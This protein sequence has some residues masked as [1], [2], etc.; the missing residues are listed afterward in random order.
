MVKKPISFI[1]R[2]KNKENLNNDTNINII[3]TSNRK[4][5]IS[6]TQKHH[7]FSYKSSNS[8]KKFKYF[9]YISAATYL[10]DKKRRKLNS[11][12]I[13]SSNLLKVRSIDY[14]N[15]F[16]EN[17]DYICWYDL[18]NLSSVIKDYNNNV[19]SLLDK[20]SNNFHLNQSNILNQPKYHNGAL[21][22]NGNQYLSNTITT[23]SIQSNMSIYIVMKQ[24]NNNYDTNEQ[25]ILVGHP[26]N[27]T[28]N[29]NNN[30][31]GFAF[32]GSDNTNKYSFQQNYN[33]NSNILV[34]TTNPTLPIDFGLYEFTFNNGEAKLYF[35]GEL[36]NSSTFSFTDGDSGKFNG[37]GLGARYLNGY[38]P[39]FSG[40]VYE[41]IV[42]NNILNDAD[43]YKLEKYLI[44]KWQTSQISSSVN[45]D[46]Y[47]W[48]D[49]SSANNF[50]L[51]G[52][53]VIRW[54]DKNGK[55]FENLDTNT[56]PIFE[57][58]KI[59]LNNQY[60]TFDGELD[61][62]NSTF[63]IICE[64]T[65]ATDNTGIFSSIP[66][67]GIND[68]Q[69]GL[70]FTN[71]SSTPSFNV[72]GGGTFITDNN[73]VIKQVYEVVYN[74]GDCK[75]Y[76]NG[77][78]VGTANFGSLN[79]INKFLLGARYINGVVDQSFSFIG[80]IYEFI[81]IPRVITG[82]EKNK[83]YNYFSAK[84]SVDCKLT[85]PTENSILWFDSN[86]SNYITVNGNNNITGITDISGNNT[87]TIDNT[88]T[89]P[90]LQPIN[91]LNNVNGMYL[92][93]S[94]IGVTNNVP[95]SDSEI[96]FFVVF[97]AS[98]DMIALKNSE[99][100]GRLIG[101]KYTSQDDDD[102]Y[103]FNINSGP[104]NTE[105]ISYLTAYGTQY[106]SPMRYD[107]KLN[108]YSIR[109][110]G[111]IRKLYI[112]DVYVNEFNF[113]ILFN[114][115][116]MNIGNYQI[117]GSNKWKGYLCEMI[118]YNSK[119]SE[120]EYNRTMNYLARKWGVDIKQK[121]INEY[122]NRRKQ[123]E[124]YYLDLNYAFTTNNNYIT[125]S[126]TNNKSKTLNINIT[127]IVKDKLENEIN[128][129]EKD[130]YY[131]NKIE[132]N[133]TFNI[134]EYEQG[135]F[136]YVPNTLQKGDY[137]GI[138]NINNFSIEVKGPNN[139][140]YVVPANSLRYIWYD[141]WI[142]LTYKPAI[143]VRLNNY[144]ATAN[145]N[146]T[147]YLGGWSNDYSNIKKLFVMNADTN[148]L[149][150]ETSNIYFGETY[151]ADFVMQNATGTV[152]IRISD[153]KDV[154]GVLISAQLDQ[155][156]IYNPLSISL[157]HFFNGSD[158]YT[159]ILTNWTY[160][161]TTLDVWVST[162]S[163]FSNSTYLLTSDTIQ[164]SD[165]NYTATFTNTFL[166]G[167]YY[168]TIKSNDNVI[169]YNLPIPIVITGTLSASINN[170]THTP[171]YEITLDGWSQ[172]YTDNTPNLYLYAYLNS[173]YS[174]EP[175]L[176][177]TFTTATD[178]IYTDA[179][180]ITF[181]D[182]FI[183]NR[184]FY[185]KLHDKTTR[186]GY[187]NEEF[188]KNDPNNFIPVLTINTNIDKNIGF[189]NINNVY[190]ITFSNTENY[191]IGTYTNTWYVLIGS[192][193][194]GYNLTLITDT[195]ITN[196]ELTFSY[197]PTNNNGTY[198][199]YVSN[200]NT[201][202]ILTGSD[203][204]I[205]I[206][207]PITF[208]SI[209]AKI[210]EN[211][212]KGL[213]IPL[214]VTGLQAWYDA[215]D[216]TSVTKNGSS[217]T[218]WLDKSG[219]DNDATVSNP[220]NC[221]EYQNDKIYFN[222]TDQ[223]FNIPNETLP[224]NDTSYTIFIIFDAINQSGGFL[225]GGDWGTQGGVN[226]FRGDGSSGI[227]NYWWYVDTNINTGIIGGQ[228][229]ILMGSY[230]S[231]GERR[232][233]L[234]ISNTVTDTPTTRIQTQ[235]NNYIGKTSGGEYL[236]GNLHEILI[237][238]KVLSSDEKQLI[239]GY[240]CWKWGLV[241]NLSYYHKYKFYEPLTVPVEPKNPK[242][243]NGLFSWYDLSNINN[244]NQT[245]LNVSNVYDM[246]GLYSLDIGTIDKPKYVAGKGLYFDG[247][248]YM[249]N[250]GVSMNLNN[251]TIFV[252]F[253]DDVKVNN[254]G[255]ITF[256]DYNNTN[257]TDSGG[258]S[259][260]ND[261]TNN[262][263]ISNNLINLTANNGQ[264]G[265]YVVKN[266]NN[267][268][269]IR[270]NGSTNTTDTYVGDAGVSTDFIMG[271]RYISNNVDNLFN[272]YIKEVVIYN[273]P[274]SDI[275]I[276]DLEGYLAWKWNLNP[277]L[278]NNHPHK[279][280]PY[281]TTNF[282]LNPSS[283]TG[284]LYTWF[285]GNNINSLTLT[286]DEVNTWKD[287]RLDT[288]MT[289][290]NV[291]ANTT[292]I[293]E[294][295]SIEF[296]GT[297][298]FTKNSDYFYTDIP[299]SI[300]IVFKM[301][302]TCDNDGRLLSLFNTGNNDYDEVNSMGIG[303]D[304]SN[305]NIKIFYNNNSYG[306]TNVDNNFNIIEYIYNS[307]NENLYTYLNGNY[308][309]TENISGLALN[310]N[311]IMIGSNTNN[312]YFKGF[313]NEIIINYN[314]IRNDDRQIM[315]GYLAWKWKINNVL[316]GS[317]PYYTSP[318]IVIRPSYEPNNI[319]NL[320]VW[321]DANYLRYNY[322]NDEGV[323][324]WNNRSNFTSFFGYG[325]N[326]PTFKRWGL[327]GNGILDFNTSQSYTLINDNS[328]QY[329]IDNFTFMSVSRLKG[330]T[331][332][333]IFQGVSNNLLIGYWSGR[334]DVVFT[335]GWIAYNDNL[336]DSNWDIYTYVRK[337]DT[338]GY[339]SNRGTEIPLSALSAQGLRGLRYNG[340]ETSDC[341][342]AE[343]LIY[344]KT[345]PLAYVR[346]LEGYLAWKWGLQY[347][348]PI[349]HPYR[350]I[351]PTKDNNLYIIKLEGWSAS[352]NITT[353]Y[354]FDT[355]TEEYLGETEII[356]G[357]ESIGYYGFFNY[358]FLKSENYI[359]VADNTTIGTSTI[360][361]EIQEPLIIIPPINIV[362]ENNDSNNNWAYYNI[363]KTFNFTI[364][365]YY[366]G[367][368]VD[369][370]DYYQTIKVFVGNNPNFSNLT[371]LENANIVG[372]QLSFNINF[373]YA[374]YNTDTLYFYV[375]Y[376]DTP[377]END[378]FVTNAFVFF[379]K[380]V[381]NFTLDHYNYYNPYY[382]TL[383]FPQKIALK[384][385]Y[386]YYSKD[387][388]TYSDNIYAN[389]TYLT[390]ATVNNYNQAQFNATFPA[391]DTGRYYITIS[392]I[393]DG[394]TR[395][396]N[397]INVN[398]TDF[399]YVNLVNYSI[400]KNYGFF[401]STNEYTITLGTYNNATYPFSTI[402]IFYSN[403]IADGDEDLTE[404]ASS[405]I[406]VVNTNN[407]VKATFNFDNSTLQYSTLYFYATA[408]FNNVPAFDSFTRSDLINCFDKANFNFTLDHYDNSSPNFTVTLTGWSE[409]LYELEPL[410]AYILDNTQTLLDIPPIQLNINN[411]E[412]NFVFD[413]GFLD[414]GNYYLRI[415]ES[416]D[417]ND[418]GSTE[419]DY[420]I[421]TPIVVTL[422]NPH[423][424]ITPEKPYR[425]TYN[426]EYGQKI[427]ITLDTYVDNIYLYY[428]ESEYAYYYLTP[429]NDPITENNNYKVN[430]IDNSVILYIT[431]KIT[432]L[433]L[434]C[435]DQDNLTGNNG[436]SSLIKYVEKDNFNITLD[437]YDNTTDN[438]DITLGG[439]DN[440]LLGENIK[441]LSKDSND[442]YTDMNITLNITELNNEFTSNFTYEFPEFEKTKLTL[443]NE[444]NTNLVNI[445]NPLN[446]TIVC[447]N[448]DSYNLMTSDD[449]LSYNRYKINTYGDIRALGYN[450]NIWLLGTNNGAKIYYSYDGKDFKPSYNG[451][452][453]SDINNFYWNGKLWFALGNTGNILWSVNGTEWNGSSIY[454][455]SS[456]FTS[457]TSNSKIT[458]ATNLGAD[459]LCI[460]VDNL[461]SWY[462]IPLGNYT[463]TGGANIIKTDGFLFVAGGQGTNQITY[464]YGGFDWTGSTSGNAIL[465]VSCNSLEWN[466]ILWLAGGASGQDENNLMYS[467]DG[468]NWTGITVS[469]FINKTI[470]NIEWN[471]TL[472]LAITND[473]IGYSY[474][475][476]NWIEIANNFGI[477]QFNF[478]KSK[479]QQIE[480][481]YKVNESTNIDSGNYLLA[482]NIANKA[483]YSFDGIKWGPIVNNYIGDIYY[484]SFAN[485][486]A[487]NGDM[488]MLGGGGNNRLMW[489]LNGINFLPTYANDY[490]SV[491]K[492]VT[493][494]KIWVVAGDGWFLAY[495]Y[496]G[497]T[498]TQSTGVTI[499]LV[500]NTIAVSENIWVAGGGDSYAQINYS[501]DGINW[502]N[503]ES[504][505]GVFTTSCKKIIYND[506]L[507]VGIG[508]DDKLGYSYDGINWFTSPS[509]VTNY[510]DAGLDIDYY[511]KTWIIIGTLAT[512][513]VIIKSTDGI[514]W[515][516]L[517][518]GFSFNT[519][520]SVKWINNKWMISGDI[521]IYSYD[522]IN[523]VQL[524][525]T[526]NDILTVCTT[527]LKNFIS[528]KKYFTG[529]DSN[530][531][532]Y[533]SYNGANWLVV[534]SGSNYMQTWCVK[535][536]KFDNFY[537]AM[538]NSTWS[539]LISYNGLEWYPMSLPNIYLTS[540]LC[541]NVY[542]FKNYYYAVGQG[543]YRVIYSRDGLIWQSLAN[544][545]NLLSDVAKSIIEFKNR[546][547]ICGYHNT[548]KRGMIVSSNGLDFTE[549]KSEI[550]L[551]NNNFNT[552]ATDGNILVAGST[553]GII[554]TYDGDNWFGINESTNLVNV[555]YSISYNGTM[556]I[557]ACDGA[558]R[559]LY[560]YNGIDWNVITQLNNEFNQLIFDISWQGD[561]WIA[562]GCQTKKIMY[563]YNG[564]AWY[565]TNGNSIISSSGF[566]GLDYENKINKLI[567]SSYI[568][569]NYLNYSYDGLNWQNINISI[570]KCKAICFNKIWLFGGIGTNRLMYSINGFD[571]SLSSGNSL[572]DD[573]VNSICTNQGI[574]L[575][576][577][578]NNNNLIYSYN[579]YD[580]EVCTNDTIV[581]VVNT[582]IWTGTIFIA[583]GSTGHI[584]A[585]SDDGV[586][587]YQSSDVS[588][589]FSECKAICTNKKI[590]LAGGNSNKI[591]Y[592]YDG[593]IW[594]NN[595]IGLITRCNAI[596]NNNKLFVAGGDRLIYSYNGINWNLCNNTLSEITAITWNGELFIAVGDGNIA[597]SYDGITWFIKEQ[598]NLVLKYGSTN[599]GYFTTTNND[600][601]ITFSLNNDFNT[602]GWITKINS[603]PNCRISLYNYDHS[604]SLIVDFVQ[605]LSSTEFTGTI[606]TGTDN[607]DNEEI[608][609]L[610]LINIPLT[611]NTARLLPTTF[612]DIIIVGSDTR[613]YN[614]YN[615]L[616]F[617]GGQ[618]I[619]N[620]IIA[621]ATNG[622]RFLSGQD[623][624]NIFYSDDGINWSSSSSLFNGSIYAILYNKIS[625]KWQAIGDHN[626][627]K[628]ISYSSNGI[629]WNFGSGY[630]FS[631][632]NSISAKGTTWVVGGTGDVVTYSTDSTTWTPSDANLLMTTCYGLATDGHKFIGVGN[633][634]N[635]IIYSSDGITW[636]SCDT[637]NIFN[638]GYGTCIASNGEVWVAG[639]N[640]GSDNRLVYSYDGF[641]WYNSINGNSIFSVSVIN[642]SYID[643]KGGKYFYA[644]SSLGIARSK[645]G[646]EWEL[647]TNLTTNC[648]ISNNILPVIEPYNEIEI[649][650]DINYTLDRNIQGFVLDGSLSNNNIYPGNNDFTLTFNTT[651]TLPNNKYL[652][653]LV[654]YGNL[655]I[656]NL[657]Y[658]NNPQYISKYNYKINFDIKLLKMYG[659]TLW[660]DASNKNNITYDS[661]NIISNVNDISGESNNAENNVSGSQPIYE[662]KS[663]FFRGQYQTLNNS[664]LNIPQTVFNNTS[665]YTFFQVF[666]YNNNNSYI[667]G[668]QHDGNNTYAI[669][670]IINN[671][672]YRWQASLGNNYDAYIYP[673]I[674]GQKYLIT[675]T[676]DGTTLY[677][678]KNGLIVGSWNTASAGIPDDLL[679]DFC[680]IGGWKYGS[681]T[682]V[683]NVRIHELLFNEKYLYSNQIENIESYL[684]NKWQ[685]KLDVTHPYSND[686]NMKILTSNT[687]NNNI[688]ADFIQDEIALTKVITNNITATLENNP[689]LSSTH[690]VIIFNNWNSD[691]ST[692]Y[693]YIGTDLSYKERTYVKPLAVN[694]SGLYGYYAE[695]DVVLE[696]FNNTNYLTVRDVNSDTFNFDIRVDDPNN[697]LVLTN[698][699]FSLTTDPVSLTLDNN[700]SN[701]LITGSFVTTPNTLDLYACNSIYTTGDITTGNIGESG[702]DLILLTSIDS[703]NISDFITNGISISIQ[704][705][706]LPIYIIGITD[707]GAYGYSNI[708]TNIN[709]LLRKYIVKE[710]FIYGIMNES[711]EFKFN[712]DKIK[713]DNEI[714]N[715]NEIEYD[716]GFDKYKTFE[717][718]KNNEVIERV[719]I[720]FIDKKEKMIIEKIDDTYEI[721]IKYKMNNLKLYVSNNKLYENR[722]YLM[723]LEI[724]ENKIKIK[725]LEEFLLYTTNYLQIESDNI[726]LE[727]YPPIKNNNINID[728]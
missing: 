598:T 19:S 8:S 365:S 14:N 633:G 279:N 297:S 150:T 540:N 166:E 582:I 690:P 441:L 625:N 400:N 200:N 611:V 419:I 338:S 298:K 73:P 343:V 59:K 332:A 691:I 86:N 230:E 481:I 183:F 692:I 348:L 650:G 634:T 376:N 34:D 241:N 382:I 465:N 294:V 115:N 553:Q 78:E 663:I 398:I 608:I 497:F 486:I 51:D 203:I 648:I 333:R 404:L 536:K 450:G 289:G 517:S 646:V 528:N 137:Y 649:T 370:T 643:N 710:R 148:T 541:W 67:N 390:S 478:I 397:D 351:V 320:D 383:G 79:T 396:S 453:I 85:N 127:D 216:P 613:Y 701:T 87:F 511:N 698:E 349:T 644:C 293:T 401:Q 550:T 345:L 23:Q 531:H 285:D 110:D 451:N 727:I 21:L 697:I 121:Q 707:A 424:V 533:Y 676:Y 133:R 40:E 273:T 96:T 173:D 312:N 84:W 181:T 274:L 224:Y 217:V 358:L 703:N 238:N 352:L 418:F 602:I 208:T 724:K 246:T 106:I 461:S 671:E 512:V 347:K 456:V 711:N 487:F 688:N 283:I 153:V 242:D 213:L 206:D 356:I 143:T 681:T 119:L 421:S 141:D 485:K 100:N 422:A 331:N 43:R 75:L 597:T 499:N 196:N 468:I 462:G 687:V 641:N 369:I 447:G 570:D 233:E 677:I 534:P 6:R 1:D 470:K 538:G 381:L 199:F 263:N 682:D 323:N 185:L 603:I 489:S 560:S 655:Y 702:Y 558:N 547:Y 165:P 367:Q 69:D 554:Y 94:Y 728:N 53:K 265:I 229:N 16:I 202:Y 444:F 264:S 272:G 258:T 716:N 442:V 445:T 211:Q 725:N 76:V 82:L 627:T 371:Y 616:N 619:S 719:N 410:Y 286:N 192:D 205:L 195:T 438:Y 696:M 574:T 524:N 144:D 24:Y 252:V 261:T 566:G 359:T 197:Q 340:G 586:T 27:N 392:N 254:S 31:T 319:G 276:K 521:T 664:Y 237:F 118:L 318:P 379:D 588:G 102:P 28:D 30:N 395:T 219:N 90:V 11:N 275:D 645:N 522:S 212:S 694:F 548:G 342:I 490:F 549:I 452:I 60:L 350:F 498:W 385:L 63:L 313:I 33:A 160:E 675:V 666:T 672:Y 617:T 705:T 389:Q 506:G 596:C 194:S 339:F 50:D 222:G 157:D 9:N 101:F 207:T 190:T 260:N 58:N 113:G 660:I 658:R 432:N 545:S 657:E 475:G 193:N 653:E 3:K 544:A 186:N 187:Y 628:S 414:A 394:N 391:P 281:G 169:N 255:L 354:V 326:D 308:I 92:D 112:N 518:T 568:G 290:T 47:L 699:I 510:F 142:G 159:I 32:M 587:W 22:F 372:D 640:S 29:D 366:Q 64:S 662:N 167:F 89:I 145:P 571:F 189:N 689:T 430:S 614:S 291:V 135:G 284:F 130:D 80:N 13:P 532:L 108:I 636:L 77:E 599:S 91:G 665:T 723:D 271:G 5:I 68:Y 610:N 552:F 443:T 151:Q 686:T 270:N 583:G 387:D 581:G 476:L 266:D 97:S 45:V 42:I 684:A 88:S 239:E 440:S 362:L 708:I 600:P 321:N 373:D 667:S 647:L 433:Y 62:N 355:D 125:I 236:N 307:Q 172:L 529:S 117:G 654:P 139:F 164:F 4:K 299:F 292:E 136:F 178:I 99:L 180:R 10:G 455:T 46:T 537:I 140:Y 215:G 678:R 439:W 484:M 527:K 449:G 437:H 479:N 287:I 503:S 501:Y 278:P 542:K 622:S 431:S 722:M 606:V 74:N 129:Y 595:T 612:D 594:N 683:A 427:K 593:I 336:A 502:N 360:V 2:L 405:P 460:L 378:T 66:T 134:K 249:M 7:S 584:L 495:S 565:D 225:G 103:V 601:T 669:S 434:F 314:A 535:I 562:G 526:M 609:Y 56:Q 520:N 505:N 39:N 227:I 250:Q 720:E 695:F 407:V 171:P 17:L 220:Y 500:V 629:N 472:W 530:D 357:N 317:H 126:D 425:I 104:N 267:S 368:L 717:L 402:R 482:F 282:I 268:I 590:I 161:Y 713:I 35:N 114:Y 81:I 652:T 715:S 25:G 509:Q 656:D 573:S 310:V 218:A 174:D 375:T 557:A 116:G 61:L 420:I 467:N 428:G 393:P 37:L 458:I 138:N 412:S 668:K 685:I 71:Y 403:I 257:D 198:Y 315:E 301:D 435:F 674:L 626:S 589:Y 122:V 328:E 618:I 131:F 642:I 564:I 132:V 95:I 621:L 243:Y 177:K 322:Q 55:V 305:N 214:T 496:D 411:L 605:T 316:N 415:S 714:I 416:N 98:N 306:V 335:E 83:L 408:D 364:T 179:Y 429:I 448:L 247:T 288:I 70:V 380:P 471:G 256:F 248:S 240:L 436:K 152:N 344:S 469:F 325:Y 519:I 580:W 423:Y 123:I 473:T 543:T 721:R 65:S 111:T 109:Y 175:V 244:V 154:N 259:I 147:V 346:K 201:G 20:S 124:S 630:T 245:N 49:A 48:L 251:Y 228:P 26:L 386:V 577:G 329:I 709:N 575:C 277:K 567:Y 209:T 269:T 631:S 474:D 661:N 578:G 44:E 488:W 210:Y 324:T 330:M 591:I 585:T 464:S 57:G 302:A 523:W 374:T 494:N 158:Q 679:S 72:V 576:G 446:F 168:I 454:S 680:T 334:K 12:Y 604:K 341:Q 712:C 492:D 235:Y 632:I 170:T 539:M 459:P 525:N 504:G 592:S 234:N 41:I 232:L 480:Q 18:S 635:K 163:D 311:D 417:P 353:L 363:S 726:K 303:R 700:N 546:L 466:G 718:I 120:N 673:F 295:N 176:F 555:V 15:S 563:S 409:D 463:F 93:N 624:G 620:N 637:N 226:A 477:S 262:F 638:N 491:V 184:N 296:D 623:N 156:I 514:N 388:P 337:Q 493:W 639:A 572:L 457:M 105:I 223:F 483:M 561:K 515:S 52:N 399:I 54:K 231:G 377:T 146:L 507:F 651:E 155:P 149:I 384:N 204:Q 615:N 704:P 128:I 569:L 513:P 670:L 38:I 659:F 559:A 706:Q 309:N 304:G 551:E 406:T 107:N 253:E 508:T 579:N 182:K 191:D 413:F 607:F 516:S 280:Y 36:V 693:A 426:D 327:N 162:N 556:F 361:L 300:F 188:T 221:P